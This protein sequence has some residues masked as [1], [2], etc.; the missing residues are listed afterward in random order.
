MIEY[1]IRS[2]KLDVELLP[3]TSPKE[4]QLLYLERLDET[5][6]IATLV[7]ESQKKCVKAH[8]DQTISPHTSSES[9]LILL[10][11]QANDKLGVGKFDPMWHGSYIIK[12]VLQKGACELV[13][14]K[15]NALSQPQNGLYLKNYYG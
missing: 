11:D 6:F 9:D 14:Y 4:E 3:N 5:H 1:E 12:Y 10:Y 2:L 8:F 13:D 15:G 7:I